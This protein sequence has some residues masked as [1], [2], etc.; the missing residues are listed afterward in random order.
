MLDFLVCSLLMF[1]IG[2][3]G[4]QTQFATSTP[5]PVHQEFSAEAMQQHPGDIKV[6]IEFGCLRLG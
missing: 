3:G 5:A 6:I 2:T 1:V 4:T